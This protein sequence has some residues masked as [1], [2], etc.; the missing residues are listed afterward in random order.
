MLSVVRIAYQ[1]RKYVGCV[2]YLQSPKSHSQKLET[3]LVDYLEIK[4]Y[5]GTGGDGC[6]SLHKMIRDR[7]KP[8]G[9]DGGNGGNIIIK[10]SIAT[11]DFSHIPAIIHAEN[12]GKGLGNNGKGP[13]GK[14]TLILVPQVIGSH[15]IE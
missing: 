8:D 4:V 10:S 7:I 13:R 14:D 5:G 3:Y 6:V 11:T 2:R 1:L 15:E 12:G 9:G